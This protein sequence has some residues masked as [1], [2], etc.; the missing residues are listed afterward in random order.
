MYRRNCHASSNFDVDD[1]ACKVLELCGTIYIASDVLEQDGTATS[2]IKKLDS[3]KRG[4][5]RQLRTL[6]RNY[7]SIKNNFFQHLSMSS[8]APGFIRSHEA[9]STFSSS[10]KKHSKK[11]KLGSPFSTV[12]IFLSSADPDYRK[13]L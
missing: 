13:S 1:F 8:F 6:Q 11:E 5:I 7:E 2:L 4:N 12:F 9:K 3:A 10:F